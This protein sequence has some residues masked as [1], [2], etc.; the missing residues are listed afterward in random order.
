[1]YFLF[2]FFFLFVEKESYLNENIVAK[3]QTEE[4]ML[5]FLAISH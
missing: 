5:S 3:I 4:H 2:F 1:M